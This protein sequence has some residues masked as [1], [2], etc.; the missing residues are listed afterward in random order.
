MKIQ[1]CWIING[2]SFCVHRLRCFVLYVTVVGL[3]F[4]NLLLLHLLPRYT[5]YSRKFVK[6]YCSGP[7][8]EN[9][10]LNTFVS[11]CCSGIQLVGAQVQ[12]LCNLK[13]LNEIFTFIL[14]IILFFIKATKVLK[15][16]K[17]GCNYIINLFI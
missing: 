10:G 2:S 6:Y 3:V 1:R 7:F 12:K 14:L 17:S 4:P 11:F 16:D 5:K 9:E 8:G 13:R 15:T